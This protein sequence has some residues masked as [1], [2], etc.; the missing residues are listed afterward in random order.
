MESKVYIVMHVKLDSS[1][2]FWINYDW[3]KLWKF[4]F[5]VYNYFNLY[6]WLG[7]VVRYNGTFQISQEVERSKLYPVL[8]TTWKE[9]LLYFFYSFC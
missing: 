2:S 1:N 7:D 5:E 6:N 9:N 4:F 8:S 3:F